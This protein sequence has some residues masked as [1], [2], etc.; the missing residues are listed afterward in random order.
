MILL[1]MLA[2][3]DVNKD[4]ECDL[5]GGGCE[6]SARGKLSSAHVEGEVAY[7]D[8]PPMGGDHNACW[9][10]WGVYTTELDDERWVHNMEHGGIVFL[11]RCPDGCDEEVALLTSLVQ[12]YGP[13]A[14]LTPY[15]ALPVNFAAVSW[16]HRLLS[17]CLDLDALRNFYTAHVDQGPES[18]TASPGEGCM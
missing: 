3:S 5:C 7:E 2:C 13:T 18:S 4:T 14:I 1:L 15:E 11:Y 6:E 16:G 8:P 12:S 10:E 9:A 17:D